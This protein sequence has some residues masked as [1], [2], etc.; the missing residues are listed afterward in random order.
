MKKIIIAIISIIA[1]GAVVSLA[2]YYV[3]FNKYAPTT[4]VSDTPEG[5]VTTDT[6]TKTTTTV[7]PTFTMADVATHKDASSCYTVIGGSVYDLSMWVNMHPGGKGA[8]LSICGIDGTDRFMNKHKGGA[9][10]MGILAR[11]K[12]GVIK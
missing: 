12:I 3:N 1:L 6:K 11:Y 4:Y 2:W 9:K 8:I 7:T 10:Y 5:E